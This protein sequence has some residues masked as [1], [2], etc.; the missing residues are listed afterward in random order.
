VLHIVSWGFG[1]WGLPVLWSLWEKTCLFSHSFLW[2]VDTRTELSSS[3][4][5]GLHF[6][7]HTASFILKCEKIGYG[8]RVWHCERQ[9]FIWGGC[10]YAPSGPRAPLSFSRSFT[11]TYEFFQLWKLGSVGGTTRDQKMWI[12]N[13]QTCGKYFSKEPWGLAPWA[14]CSTSEWR[15]KLGDWT[16]PYQSVLSIWISSSTHSGMGSTR[17]CC[18]HFTMICPLPLLLDLWFIWSV[19]T[20]GFLSPLMLEFLSQTFLNPVVRL[21][22]SYSTSTAIVEVV[23]Q[24]TLGPNLLLVC[25]YWAFCLLECSFLFPWHHACIFSFLSVIPPPSPVLSPLFSLTC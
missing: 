9:H 7:S 23:T 20:S 10:E 3:F 25:H 2:W 6:L 22:P 4:Q 11:C 13:L 16:G 24:S 1:E 18:H 17:C 5:P 12:R 8:I 15:V 14:P 21:S 19:V